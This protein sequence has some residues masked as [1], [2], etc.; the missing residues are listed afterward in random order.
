LQVPV[1]A[2]EQKISM[3]LEQR[4]K[5]ITGNTTKLTDYESE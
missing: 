2:K 4:S 5:Y 1:P 3:I